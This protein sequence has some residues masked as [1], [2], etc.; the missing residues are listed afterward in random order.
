[1][2]ESLSG[3]GKAAADIAS[4]A[5]EASL[6]NGGKI[7]FNIATDNVQVA[8][9]LGDVAVKVAK[10]LGNTAVKLGAIYAVCYLARPI[11]DTACKKALGGERKDQNVDEAQPKCLL[12]LVRCFTDERFLE[13]L[14]D[15]ESGDIERRL[16]K[17]LAQIGFKA[18]GLTVEIE[19]MDEVNQRKRAIKKRKS[20]PTKMRT[21]EE[22]TETDSLDAD[23]QS[24]L[25]TREDK[26][27][28]IASAIST[29]GSISHE[30]R[31]WAVVG[32][33]LTKVLT[34]RLRIVLASELQKWYNVLCQPPDEIDKQVY[35]KHKKRLAPSKVSLNYENIN[36]NKLHKSSHAYVYAVKDHLSLAKLFVQPFMSKFTGFDQTMDLSAVLAVMCEATPFSAA[37]VDAKALKS[38]VRNKWAHCNFSEWTEPD[39]NDAFQK[40]E[41]FV[42]K[43]NLPSA[44]EKMLCDDLDS[45]KNKGLQLCFG[46][47]VDLELLELVTKEVA[48]LRTAIKTWKIESD[49]KMN[50]LLNKLSNIES[51][52]QKELRAL[53]WRI[54]RCEKHGAENSKEVK[55]LDKRFNTE[56]SKF[57]SKQEEKIPYVF[58]APD[59][60]QY[61]SGRSKELQDLQRI[62]KPD[63]IEVE[64]KVRI[65]AVCGLGGVGK[66]SLVTEYA[67]RMKKH[68]FGGVYW[69]SAEDDMFFE[70]SVNDTALKLGALLGTI[71]LTMTNT[72]FRIGQTSKPCLIVLDCL[73]QLSLSANMLKFLSLVSR[74]NISADLVMMTRR[75]ERKLV[76]EVSSLHKD[77]CLSLQ[78]FE[79]EEAKQ[80]MFHRT[81]LTP[82]EE[83]NFISEILLNELGGLPLVLEQAGA[84]IKALD[85]TLFDFLEQFE[86]E[87]LKLLKS[88]RAKATSLFESRERL[89]LHTTWSLNIKH[90]KESPH[91]MSAIRLMKAYAFLNPNEIEKELVNVGERPIE[92]KTFRDC[93]SSP[94]GSRQVVKLL[95]DFSLFTYV[96]AHS[97]GTHRLVQELIRKNVEPEEKA[98]SFLDAVRLLSFAFSKCTSP[99][100]LLGDVSIKKRLKAYDFR[101]HHSQYHLWS[102]LCFH[103]FY[104]QKNIEKLL[105]NVDPKC[106]DSLFVFETAK[107]LYECVVHLSANQK[108][109]QAK[110]TLNFAYRILDWIPVEEYDTVQKSLSNNSLFP[111]HVIPLQKCLQIVIK[112]SCVPFMSSLEPL[113][114]KPRVIPDASDSR[115]LEQ[116]IKKVVLDGN[117]KFKDGLY[118]EAVASYS[119]AIHMSRGTTAFNALLLTNRASAYIKLKQLDDALKDANEYI[120]RFP[121]CWKGYARKALALD[122]KVS[123]EIAAAL[124][125]YYFKQKDWRCIFSGYKPFKGAFPGLKE[126]ISLCHT[127]D[128]LMPA[129]VS[130]NAQ[131]C[132]RIVVLGSQEYVIKD[133]L[134]GV[135]NCIMTGTKL[136][137]SV[138]VNFVD[139]CVCSLLEK[140]MFANLSFTINKGQIFAREGSFVKVFNCNFTSNDDISAAVACKGVLN[141]EQCNFTN[142]KA[143]GLLCGGPGSMVVDNCTFSGNVKAGLEVRE[144][145][146]LTVRNSRMYN[147]STEGLAIGPKAAKCDVFHCQIYHNARE[148]IAAVDE[149]K[150]I[151]LIRN[152]VFENYESGIY[153]RNSEVDMRENKFFDNDAWGIWSANNS[154]C[155]VSMNEVFGN[156]RGGIRVGKRFA[157]KEFPPSIVELNTVH[158]NIGPGIVDTINNFEDPR[159]NWTDTDAS[160]IHGDYKSAEYN[161][162]VE[163]RNEESIIVNQSFFFLPWCSDCKGK[164][165]DLKMCGKCFTTGY[166]NKNCQKRHWSKH[167]QLCDVLR[168]KSSFLIPTMERCIPGVRINFHA[169][170]LDEVGPEH[171]GPPPRNG[172]RF[173]VKL[174]T[175]FLHQD[176]PYLIYIYDRSL[177]IYDSF[178][179]KYIDH[180]VK[181]FGV[182]CERKFQEKELFLYCVFEES[183]KL[184]LFINNF[185]DFQKW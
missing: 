92:D 155:N 177:T 153:I 172:Q 125:Y 5:L 180:L 78:C 96:H 38:N 30:E 1:M 147:N 151:T 87:R 171:S 4:R 111:S 150:C 134:M 164:C 166:C 98:K 39:F 122:E 133:P 28:V 53:T 77:C 99:K 106:L 159:V 165:V 104:L 140:C 26:D 121:D 76:E 154:F 15:Y 184:R 63:D 88:H 83:A 169:K 114:D 183:A 101:K 100:H 127:V 157:G 73:D 131:D 59:R 62:L 158:D 35:S 156:K 139:T 97:V 19:N 115:D 136:D 37:A 93:V 179:D 13:V 41:S 113:N 102:K 12:V 94:L 168:Q 74:Q 108:Q 182:L 143:G 173:I 91:G 161:Q 50:L 54:E 132:M 23:V 8:R 119:S 175:D 149:S 44:D 146:I 107:V 22:I 79:V 69:F 138:T 86:T 14:A 178:E 95:T 47:A 162:N 85:C 71:D 123:A 170:N 144:N 9:E 130:L 42:K 109:H 68:Y 29:S 82:D 129:L 18:K 185:P 89:A 34:P 66:T 110:R 81:G 40:I 43:L 167:K 137:C 65:A 3:A 118:K 70:Q 6:G 126:R 57:S 135:M 49:S 112:K 181:E 128:Q 141:A 58:G 116:N 2:A 46:Q 72:L 17:E 61:F 142:C 176:K 124:A 11:I 148:G 27:S 152:D 103:A 36:N 24:K 160:N 90:I 60:N 48:E 51:N 10:E 7:L 120:S 33:C 75:N 55:L 20:F 174:Q 67:Y 21:E 84:Y 56:L 163:Y 145:G 16:E 25:S 32:V 45:W 105:A 31:R 52:F 117:T 80:F 64:K